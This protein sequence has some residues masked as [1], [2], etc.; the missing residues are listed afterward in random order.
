MCVNNRRPREKVAEAM[1]GVRGELVTS[2][3]ALS[4]RVARVAAEVS[5]TLAGGGGGGVGLD[6]NATKPA[7]AAGGGAARG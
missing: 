5:A 2:R 6:A 7:A 1:R 3:E 4:R